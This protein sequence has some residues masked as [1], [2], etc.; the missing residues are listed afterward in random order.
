MFEGV[1]ADE[2]Q[3]FGKVILRLSPSYIQDRPE[4]LP[5]AIPWPEKEEVV[6]SLAEIANLRWP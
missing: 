3:W 6:D 5:A 1:S 2:I 4:L